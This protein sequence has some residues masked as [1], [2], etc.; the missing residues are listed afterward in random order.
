METCGPVETGV[1]GCL[2]WSLVFG[3]AVDCG[4]W[5]VDCGLWTVDCGLWT[6][7]WRVETEASL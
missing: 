5:T 4:L 6:V 7:D 2:G 1:R 3:G